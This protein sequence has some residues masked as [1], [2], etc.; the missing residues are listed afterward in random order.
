MAVAPVAA[1]QGQAD[2]A[3]ALSLLARAEVR[4]DSMLESS[5]AG[6]EAYVRLLL[7]ERDSTIVLLGRMLAVQPRLRRQVAE[8]VKFRSLHSDP[9][10]RHLVGE[11]P[12]TRR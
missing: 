10:F 9:R 7:G 8:N 5:Q 6:D 11:A 3:R 12:E 4:G 2:T 1:R